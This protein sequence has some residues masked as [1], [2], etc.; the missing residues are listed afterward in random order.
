[1]KEIG[2]NAKV[3]NTTEAQ[4]SM[5]KRGVHLIIIKNVAAN[6]Y[7]NNWIET[8]GNKNQPRG[9]KNM[10]NNINAYKWHRVVPIHMD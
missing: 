10:Y 3:R 6:K 7:R 1:M 5:I 8:W 2:K 9:L 4:K